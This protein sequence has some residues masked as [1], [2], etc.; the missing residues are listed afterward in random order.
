MDNQ[1]VWRLVFIVANH[2]M[3]FHSRQ[4]I[5]KYMSELRILQMKHAFFKIGSKI[6]DFLSYVMKIKLQGGCKETLIKSLEYNK[7]STKILV[8]LIGPCK[9]LGLIR[10]KNF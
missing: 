5:S 8:D 4:M 9:T 3:R 6:Q 7:M 2:N 10:W 1:L